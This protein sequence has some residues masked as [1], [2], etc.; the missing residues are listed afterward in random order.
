MTI[1]P[2]GQINYWVISLRLTIIY[3]QLSTYFKDSK[4]FVDNQYQFRRTYAVEYAYI[5]LVD[6]LMTQLDTEHVRFKRGPFPGL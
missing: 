6:R 2:Y 4:L 5:E 3:N 1:H